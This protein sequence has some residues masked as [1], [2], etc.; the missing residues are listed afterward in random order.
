MIL[1][2]FEVNADYV[3]VFAEE[4]FHIPRIKNIMKSILEI[5][6]QEGGVARK[7]ESLMKFTN[8]IYTIFEALLS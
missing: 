3:I 4:N 6:N 2:E 1:L 8:V 7:F 5:W